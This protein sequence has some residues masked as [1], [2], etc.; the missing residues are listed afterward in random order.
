MYF[1]GISLST[2][3]AAMD[4]VTRL[5]VRLASRSGLFG[6][7]VDGAGLLFLPAGD[8]KYVSVWTRSAESVMS[9]V[10]MR[11]AK[12]TGSVANG[13]FVQALARQTRLPIRLASRSELF[14]CSVVFGLLFLPAGPG[15]LWTI[16]TTNNYGDGAL[17]S[18]RG[19]ISDPLVAD[20]RQKPCNRF[21]IR[22]ASREGCLL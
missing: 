14:G 1:W 2:G 5:G 4:R 19:R 22:L 21:G 9:G 6:C 10:G 3:T 18:I 20:A 11:A 8:G 13:V 17:G 7:S 12:V 15:S 16:S